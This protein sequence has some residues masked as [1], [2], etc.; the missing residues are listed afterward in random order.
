MENSCQR[1]GNENTTASANRTTMAAGSDSSVL[2]TFL[3]VVAGPVALTLR[4]KTPASQAFWA[5]TARL[6]KARIL[7]EL[8]DRTWQLFPNGK[9]NC[10]QLNCLRDPVVAWPPKLT[11]PLQRIG[12]QWQ[13]PRKSMSSGPKPMTIKTW[14]D[15]KQPWYLKHWISKFTVRVP[16]WLQHGQQASVPC[17]LERLWWN[18]I[19]TYLFWQSTRSR[20]TF[21]PWSMP[22]HDATIIE[23][24]SQ[25]GVW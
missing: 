11:L 15:R 5:R 7:R 13:G 17:K 19:Q 21:H 18:H 12:Q 1:Q 22:M 23:E 8:V 4:R 10:L 25:H 24:S 9:L 6:K 3:S 14:I 2:S 20:K 16:R